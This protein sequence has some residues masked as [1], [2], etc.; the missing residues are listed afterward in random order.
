MSAWLGGMMKSVKGMLGY[1]DLQVEDVAGAAQERKPEEKDGL[2]K[3]L[4]GY[5]GKD[6]TSMIS[7]PVWIF[8]PVSFLQIM[9]EPLQFEELIKQAGENPDAA[10]RLA[11]LM[12]F[13]TA[14]YSCAVRNKKAFNPLLGETFHY[15]PSSKQ[16]K[17]QAEQV[18]HHPPIGVTEVTSDHYRLHLEMDIKTKFKGNTIDVIVNGVNAFDVPAFSD[19]YEWGHLETCAH[20]TIIG[21]M[22]VDHFGTVNI[23]N[24]GNGYKGVLN[25]TKCGW[26]GAGRFD[27]NGEIHDNSGKV[28]AKVHGKW[29]EFFEVTKT[30]ESEPTRIWNKA[31]VELDKW[32]HPPFVTG[33][34]AFEKESDLLTTDSRLRT[35]RY[36][37]EKGD[38]D[39][40]GREKV[41]LEEV[42][43]AARK[44]R[45]GAGDEWEPRFFKK[46][47]SEEG[48]RW[49]SKNNYWQVL[50]EHQKGEHKEATQ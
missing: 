10:L 3:Q 24:S 2:W 20:N 31:V 28:L 12:A 29:N 25:F 9:A 16:W 15:V 34:N 40:A 18:S 4:S 1:E 45:E 21:G 48:P 46:A 42:Q 22:W 7:L 41:R 49:I 23:T 17:L 30:G 11:Y 5:M 38:L 33:L 50:E 14:G 27:V 32:N 13:I 39:A 44:E 6:I 19:H 43:R 35:D 47:Q 37:L 36:N 8:E 26:L